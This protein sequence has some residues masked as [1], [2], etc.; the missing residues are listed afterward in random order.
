[1]VTLE[2]APGFEALDPASRAAGRV[3]LG[4][5]GVPVWDAADKPA[6]VYVVKGR[7]GE[8][9]RSG[10]VLDFAGKGVKISSVQWRD[11]LGK[12][13]ILQF[14]VWRN[15]GWLNGGYVCADDFSLRKFVGKV[16]IRISINKHKVVCGRRTWPRFLNSKCQ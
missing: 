9:P 12:L 4:K 1:M 2:D 11:V 5:E 8:G 16:A 6:E 15:P 14:Q 10:A 3:G 13:K 7:V